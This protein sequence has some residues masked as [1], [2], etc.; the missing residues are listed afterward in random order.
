MYVNM[1][2]G[3]MNVG[4]TFPR[5]MDI[6]FADK[7][8]RFIVIYLDDINVYSKTNEGHLMHLRGV[9]EK[10]IRYEISLN[11]K[12]TCLALKRENFLVISYLRKVLKLIVKG[13]K[14]F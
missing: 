6:S 3:L 5:E 4:A 7:I 12:K 10:C 14:L 9:F 11:P 2:F 1:P 13:L 8:G